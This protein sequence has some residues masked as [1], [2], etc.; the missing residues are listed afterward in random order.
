[1]GMSS[2]GILVFGI[3]LDED[4]QPKFMRDWMEDNDYFDFEE[5][6]W[7]HLG[8]QDAEYEDRR[9]AV[10]SSPVDLVVHCSYD[11]P[12]YVL[13]VR[14]TDI[15]ASRGYPYIFSSGFPAITGE[16]ITAFKKWAE[17]QGIEGE[18]SWI[19][20]SVLG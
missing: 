4:E 11:Y 18:P 10:D 20:C 6:L 15:N 12:M 3:A 5:F 13:A 7:T 8:M 19:L 1:M 9:K 17:E 14:G 16:Q 2:D